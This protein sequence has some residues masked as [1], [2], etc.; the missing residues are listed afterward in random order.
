MAIR[1]DDNKPDAQGLPVVSWVEDRNLFAPGGQTPARVSC[2]IR[3]DQNGDLQFVSVG[4]V[5]AGAY[6][7]A[8]PWGALVSF[9]RASADHLYY[10]EADRA[11][12]DLLRSKDKTGVARWAMADGAMVLLAHFADERPTDPMH[13]NCAVASPVEGM[14][15]HD[16]LTRE[17]ITKRSFLLERLCDGAPVWPEDK[18]FDAYKPPAPA[19]LSP[20]VEWGSNL[21]VATVLG[22]VGFGFYWLVVR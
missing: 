16:L 21:I 20:W 4:P 10:S 12:L 19:V 3:R 13:L 15:L 11:G 9:E 22:V 8:R 6:E 7:E 18:P 17:F 1:F 14:R 2:F 5:R